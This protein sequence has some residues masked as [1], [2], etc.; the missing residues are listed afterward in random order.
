MRRVAIGVV[1][2]ALIPVAWRMTAPKMPR[3]PYSLG[4]AV[5]VKPAGFA[6]WNVTVEPGITLRGL[7]REPTTPG[8]SWL[9]F[10]HGNERALLESGASVLD[11]LGA[12]AGVGLA[13]WAHRGFDGSPGT[14]SP[15]VLAADAVKVIDALGVPPARLRLLGFSMGG[16]LALHVAAELSR[17]GTPPES[18]T[19]LAAGAEFAML[20]D[21]PWVRL[22]RGDVY[23]VGADADDVKCPVHLYVGTDDTAL[24]VAQSRAIAARLGPR[25]TVTE[26]PGVTHAS[27][28]TVALP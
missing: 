13:T 17:R 8:G 12:D 5:S 26:L 22:S 3:F 4:P 10:L 2:A 20:H 27:I 9:V 11:R 19:L 18:V 14:P 21:V 6:E 24:P 7:R 15:E 23:R 28:L 16:P 1:V 25:A